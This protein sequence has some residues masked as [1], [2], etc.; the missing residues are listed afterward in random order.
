MSLQAALEPHV[1]SGAVP[2]LVALVARR[3]HDAEVVALGSREI[4]GGPVA[5]DS[6]FRISSVT[7]P[8]TAVATLVLVRDGLLELDAPIE[9]WLPELANRRVLRTIEAELDDTVAVDHPPTVRELLT[10]TWGFGTPI[11][12]P[13][14]YPIQ[15]AVA[16]LPLSQSGP[17]KPSLF[18]PPDEWI[19]LLGT[20][21][22]M[23]QPGARWM[24]N[25]GADVLAVLIARA[26]KQSF[27]ELLRERVFE[28]LHMRDTAFWC[29][30]RP[31]F[32]T[33]YAVKGDGLEVFDPIDGE[34][35]RAPA[36]PSGAAG[37]VSTVDD[38]H[39]LG[40]M[41]ASGGGD[42]LPQPLVRAM[43]TSQLT[44][45]QRAA[46]NDFVGYFTENSWGYG[47]GVVVGNDPSGA[48]GAYGWDG[49]LGAAFRV[50]PAQGKITVLLSNRAFSSPKPPDHVS[51][52]WRATRA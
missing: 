46:S 49:G 31:R 7:K 22:L 5:R 16:A 47:G 30:E 12:P 21:P 48:Q 36:F 14:K 52:F 2:G 6:V 17:P 43:L 40:A 38:L 1:T 50:D 44:D 35:S 26:A 51:D 23:H 42:V 15:R 13:G 34:W 37:L 8:I 24:Y 39:E 29:A 41:F 45:A 27:P 18:A 4:G 33:A 19:R 20:L 11:A 32:T 10:F 25:T 9:R 3:G 28:P